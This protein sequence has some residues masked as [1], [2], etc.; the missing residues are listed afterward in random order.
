MAPTQKLML[1]DVIYLRN[2][3]S[4]CVSNLCHENF[5]AITLKSSEK[6][7]SPV[8]LFRAFNESG[9]PAFQTASSSTF[10]QPDLLIQ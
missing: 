5:S 6:F 1:A 3:K 4:C 2:S 8:L 9:V 10:P 7:M